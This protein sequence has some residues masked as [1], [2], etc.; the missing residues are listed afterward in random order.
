MKL[1]FSSVEN[2]NLNQV[3]VGGKKSK[4]SNSRGVQKAGSKIYDYANRKYCHQCR[5][6]TKNFSVVC[7]NLKKGKPCS[8]KFCCRC[9]SNRY[10]EIAEE[11]ALLVDW[12][13]PKC[14]GLCICS[15]CEK[16]RGNQPI[17]R[18]IETARASGFKSVLEMLRARA[19]NKSRDFESNKEPI[20]LVSSELDK[21][22]PSDGNNDVKIHSP[23]DKKASLPK[24][25]KNTRL[26]ES[27]EIFKED[28]VDNARK[29]KSLKRLKI[30]KEVPREEAK[31]NENDDTKGPI[32]FFSNELE[33]ENSL[34]GNNDVKLGPLNAQKASLP[35]FSK[36]TKREESN[37]LSKKDNVD[38]ADKKKNLKRLKICKE[39]PREEATRN[40]NVDTKKI[41]VLFS[42]EIKK[43]NSLNGNNDV[44]PHSLNARKTTLPTFSMNTKHE[45][46]HEISKG[47]NVDSVKKKKS[48]KRFNICKEVPR[49]EAKGKTNDDIKELVVLVSCELEKKNSSDGNSNVKLCSLNAKKALLPT[50]S[51]NTKHEE[52]QE[53][54]KGENVESA[55][56][57]KGWK[58]LK[59][60][61]EVPRK[62]AKGN[63][64]DDTKE[65]FILV[66]GELE[67]GNS[68]DGNNDV[69]L[70]SLNAHK[71]SLPKMSKNTKHEESQ[72][73]LKEENVD[74]VEKNKS[75]KR[76]K[77][78]K[79]VLGKELKGNANDDTKVHNKVLEKETKEGKELKGNANDDTKVHNKVL[80]KETKVDC[81]LLILVHVSM[82]HSLLCFS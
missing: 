60:C 78:C 50:M 49:K 42:S 82:H 19:T 76:F 15:V 77:I 53:L 52:S 10:G 47:K 6:N 7:K 63:A 2:Q 20:V 17:G 27:K 75:S 25:S 14:R 22:N 74:S 56:K 3:V 24:I 21:E 30:R 70:C 18:L 61:K 54:S 4:R 16:K 57:K 32:V 51:E 39:D 44:K 67:K 81:N 26:E 65:H 11:V 12:K 59:I 36:N 8:I 13:C 38:S 48:L 31:G 40:A 66:S 33:K 45:E 23:N 9:L 28:N 46:S 69:K 5:Q 37:E 68:L 71:A 41:V 79:E 35:K 64:N 43:E 62:E 72:E 55:R 58:R 73:L 34:D 80:E 1:E 29:K